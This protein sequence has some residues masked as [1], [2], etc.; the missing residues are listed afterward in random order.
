MVGGGGRDR[1][2]DGVDQGWRRRVSS[3]KTKGNSQGTT[4]SVATRS[5]S[6]RITVDIQGQSL[7][8][9]S[10]REPGFVKEL[11]RH[12]DET[13]EE[14]QSAAPRAPSNK[15]LMLASLTVAEE[16]YEARQRLSQTQEDLA[17]KADTLHDL[18]DQVE[19]VGQGH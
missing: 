19:E 4:A 14:L 17:D 18:I 13:I 6:R 3:K 11:A 2:M 1:A 15:L 7:T 16:L 8:I 10:D 12:I 9:R 5:Q